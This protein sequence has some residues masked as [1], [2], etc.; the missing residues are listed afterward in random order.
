MFL[1]AVALAAP[2]L[3]HGAPTGSH[4]SEEDYVVPIL[5]DDRV[6][7]ED[8]RYNVDVETG[9]GIHL[10]QGGSPDALTGAIIQAGEYSWVATY[11]IK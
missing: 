6:H 4:S 5:R 2:Y 8:G 9:N 11:S 7:E 3:T 1:I 10:S